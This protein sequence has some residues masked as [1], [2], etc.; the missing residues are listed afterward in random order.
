MWSESKTHLFSHYTWPSYWRQGLCK[1]TDYC[2][3]RLKATQLAE[4]GDKS[5]AHRN[6]TQN[7]ILVK[8]EPSED[9]VAQWIKVLPLKSNY[10][11]P[12]FGSVTHNRYKQSEGQIHPKM[13]PERLPCATCCARLLA[14]IILY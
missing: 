13:V 3:Y 6:A 11:S 14:Q 10:M 5:T 9:S 2:L 12:D 7:T 8:S 1:S 4:K